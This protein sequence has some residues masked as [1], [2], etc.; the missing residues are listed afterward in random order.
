M[1][2]SEL[3]TFEK[4]SRQ[5]HVEHYVGGRSGWHRSQ[6]FAD[7]FPVAARWAG[8][9]SIPALQKMPARIVEVT[10]I[11]KE[12]TFALDS[13]A[14]LP[15]AAI[16]VASKV[17][18]AE[19]WLALRAKGANIVSTWIDEAGDGQSADYEELAARCLSEISSSD[20]VL[21]YC[22]GDE[23]LKGALIE[24][25]AALALGKP[26]HCVGSCPSLSRVFNKHSLWHFH[27]NIDGALFAIANSV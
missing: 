21:L 16:Y 19:K 18:H 25:G 15:Q 17:Q 3:Q 5:F 23:I 6:V 20:V 24:A 1:S 13:S 9:E 14:P 8:E 22:E 7:S 27:Q 26:I 11:T 12:R 10:T 2:K 4:T